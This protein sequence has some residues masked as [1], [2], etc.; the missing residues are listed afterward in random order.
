LKRERYK[1]YIAAGVTAFLV[2]AATLLLFFALFHIQVIRGMVDN[3][4][5]ILR[6]ILYGLVLAFLLLPIHRH[7]KEFLCA[8]LNEN[9]RRNERILKLVHFIA[10]VLSLVV[11]ALIIYILLAMILPQVYLSLAGFVDSLPYYLRSLQDWIMVFLHNNPGIEATV[12]PYLESAALSAQEWFQKDILPNLES[13][14]TILEWVK[15]T[16]LPG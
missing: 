6:P 9:Q 15:A 14:G 2:L 16:I 8:I 4:F 7:I 3:L 13:A 10:I 12:L 1:G 11:A 5:Q